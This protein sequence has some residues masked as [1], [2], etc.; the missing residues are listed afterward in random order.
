MNRLLIHSEVDLKRHKSSADL[1]EEL[2]DAARIPLGDIMH[3]VPGRSPPVSEEEAELA[4][5]I[6][7][8]LKINVDSIELTTTDGLSPKIY[9]VT[10][11]CIRELTLADVKR[12]V[13]LGQREVALED[14]MD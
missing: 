6:A 3:F 4:E 7:H 5:A 2:G 13:A 12:L 11:R 14:A 9:Q 10:L 8:A 1:L